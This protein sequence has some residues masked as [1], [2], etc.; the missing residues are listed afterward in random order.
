MD[1]NPPPHHGTTAH[2][3]LQAWGLEWIAIP[4]PRGSS[5]PRAGIITRMSSL[6]ASFSLHD[7]L[8]WAEH[9]GVREAGS[10]RAPCRQQ[11]QPGLLETMR[12]SRSEVHN[13]WNAL[14]IQW[15]N[16][17]LGQTL[18]RNWRKKTYCLE[19]IWY[20]WKKQKQKLDLGFSEP[21]KI[22]RACK[23]KKKKK[24]P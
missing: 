7:R 17:K 9:P 12:S 8:E 23:K 13:V 3:I 10:G 5:W 14:S 15:D 21:W 18:S 24:N 16:R 1:C 22:Q 4:L 20:T 19:D 11:S 2:G 6:L